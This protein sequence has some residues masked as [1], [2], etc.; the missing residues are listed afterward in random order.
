MLNGAGS[1]E[2]SALPTFPKTL[3]TSGKLPEQLVLDLEVLRRLGHRDARQGDGHVENAALV[4]W[5]HE[6]R[7]KLFE[8]RHGERNHQHGQ[9]NHQPLVVEHKPHGRMIEPHERTADGVLLFAMDLAHR[10]RVDDACQPARAEV[11][12]HRFA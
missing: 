3:C 12:T 7:A 11:E 4:E 5:R 6:L 10:N 2:V 1:V 9:H 8:H